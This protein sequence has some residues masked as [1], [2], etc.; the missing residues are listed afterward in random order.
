MHSVLIVLRKELR[1]NLRDR[2]SLVS[3]L[4]FGTLLTPLLVVLLVNLTVRHSQD[5]DNK[6][7]RW[8]WF[9]PSGRRICWRICASTAS[10]SSPRISTMAPRAKRCGGSAIVW[11]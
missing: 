3:A 9:T 6:R 2:R 8:R 7:C 4:L 1:E 11:C 10:T 5:Q